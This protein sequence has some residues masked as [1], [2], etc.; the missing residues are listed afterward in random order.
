MADSLTVKLFAD[1]GK[2]Y[3]PRTQVPLKGRVAVADVLKQLTVPPEKA[4]IIMLNGRHADP[5]DQVGPGDVLAVF[6]PVGGG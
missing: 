2:T 1:L 6:P 4:A 3:G 5:A